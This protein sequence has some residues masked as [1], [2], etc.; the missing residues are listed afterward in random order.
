MVIHT[1][2]RFFKNLSLFKYVLI[3]NLHPVIFLSKIGLIVLVLVTLDVF[4][5]LD[6]AAVGVSVVV[7]TIIDKVWKSQFLP[8][9]D[10]FKKIKS[11]HDL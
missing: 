1:S 10:K 3:H 6:I 2:R 11:S 9:L 5:I 4:V 7:A 8:L